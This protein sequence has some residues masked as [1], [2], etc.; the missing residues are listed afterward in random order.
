MFNTGN[1][2][3]RHILLMFLDVHT[4]ITN[5]WLVFSISTLSIICQNKGYDS[6]QRC[7]F[8]PLTWTRDW[9]KTDKWEWLTQIILYDKLRWPKS[10][11]DLCLGSHWRHLFPVLQHC[12]D[13]PIPSLLA[14]YGPCSLRYNLDCPGR[15]S[16]SIEK[17]QSKQFQY[18][19]QDWVWL[20]ILGGL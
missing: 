7:I 1:H 6:L 15:E 17:V 18:L 3:A 12:S 10:C 9:I 19:S 14:D 13:I 5:Q 20:G 11:Q 8:R 2:D 4:L 16:V